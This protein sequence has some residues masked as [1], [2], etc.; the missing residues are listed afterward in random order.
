MTST[1][2]AWTTAI[3]C[4]L[5]ACALATAA[6]AQSVD[7]RP[8]QD[9]EALPDGER[10]DA[11]FSIATSI[12]AVTDYRF[13]GVSLSNNDPA[14]QGGVELSSRTGLYVGAWS[15]T[16][17]N[18]SG[19]HAELDGYAGYRHTVWNWQLDVGAIGYL[20]PSGTD[21]NGFELYGSASR[22]IAS[23]TIK[24]GASYMPQQSNFG[25]GDGTYVFAEL[26]G[27]LPRTPFTLRA[28]LGREAGISGGPNGDKLDWL[29]GVDVAIGPTTA[30]LAW[31]D[32]DIGSDIGGNTYRS[33]IVASLAIGL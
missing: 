32:T 15:S 23:A 3:L 33:A 29:V 30:S 17:P 2:I 24:A 18:Y 6:P 25:D 26:A 12:A 21:V 10:P 20:Y 19:A 9:P 11:A 7:P 27:E 13:R 1:H 31:V 28:H 8:T 16:I 4:P 22:E 14:L 5:L